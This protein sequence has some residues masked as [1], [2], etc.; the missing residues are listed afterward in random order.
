MPKS[1]LNFFYFSNLFRIKFKNLKQ[2]N[3][4]MNANPEGAASTLPIGARDS[5]LL[6]DDTAQRKLEL[7]LK[8]QDGF[9]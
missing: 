1:K 4:K 3:L 6:V 5:A 2:R 8:Q 9:E 7:M